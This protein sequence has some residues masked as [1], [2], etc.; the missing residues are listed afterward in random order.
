MILFF[1][2]KVHFAMTIQNITLFLCIKKLWKQSN[3]KTIRPKKLWIVQK[4]LNVE[5]FNFEEL[6][7]IVKLISFRLIFFKLNFFQIRYYPVFSRTQPVY[8][9]VQKKNETV[10][11]PSPVT[12]RYSATYCQAEAVLLYPFTH[13]LNAE[14]LSAI[15]TTFELSV[16]YNG[17]VEPTR[18]V[19][20][21]QARSECAYSTDSMLQLLRSYITCV[22]LMIL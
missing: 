5:H 17:A 16:G 13:C 19:C 18:L 10:I 2:L 9:Q 4:V 14:T 8:G 6:K 22:C 20:L 15:T 12:H 3:V 21:L 7:L 1:I 11:T